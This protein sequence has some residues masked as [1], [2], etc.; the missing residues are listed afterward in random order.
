MLARFKR[1]YFYWEAVV[2]GRKLLISI[3]NTFLLP[4][5]VVVFS[6]VIIAAALLAH[7]YAVP[8]RYKFHNIME[9]RFSLFVTN[10]LSILY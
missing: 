4:I 6:L 10:I 8:F 9:V 1:R 5:T 2:T 3:L 7:M